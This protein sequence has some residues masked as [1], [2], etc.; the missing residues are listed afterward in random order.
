MLILN[1]EKIKKDFY[2]ISNMCLNLKIERALI[3]YILKKKFKS[4]EDIRPNS[5]AKEAFIILK[6]GGYLCAPKKKE[7]ISKKKPLQ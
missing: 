6:K 4:A 5:K 3:D 7:A 2:T 1:K